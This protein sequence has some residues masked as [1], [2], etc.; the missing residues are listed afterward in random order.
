MRLLIGMVGIGMAMSV[1]QAQTYDGGGIV[2]DYWLEMQTA[3]RAGQSVVIPDV[4]K[5]ACTIKLGIRGACVHPWA[6][7]GFHSAYVAVPGGRIIE[8]DGNAVL[9]A[10]YPPKIRRWVQKTRALRSFHYAYMSG[11]QAIALGVRQCPAG[12]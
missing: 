5:S 4:C 8:H 3:N 11:A 2:A 9:M 6:W 10:S 1:A 7:L 12:Y